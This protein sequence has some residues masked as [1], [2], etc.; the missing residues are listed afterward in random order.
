[1]NAENEDLSDLISFNPGIIELRRLTDAFHRWTVRMSNEVQRA[2]KKDDLT[3]QRRAARYATQFRVMI[4]NKQ[5]FFDYAKDRRYKPPL[6]LLVLVDAL[7]TQ[8]TN[9][10]VIRVKNHC[11]ICLA[12]AEL[13]DGVA[14]AVSLMEQ[15][16]V[17]ADRR[18]AG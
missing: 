17:L 4:L 1:M 12:T 2:R 5:D 18:A 9:I 8:L 10:S 6:S 15:I 14:I 11:E 13:L 3:A 7:E 16:E